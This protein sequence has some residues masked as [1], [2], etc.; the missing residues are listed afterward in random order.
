MRYFDNYS[1]DNV[2]SKLLYIYFA[3]AH[4]SV[5][6]FLVLEDLERFNSKVLR[7]MGSVIP[8]GIW[9]LILLIAALGFI[10]MAIQEGKSKNISMV[11]AGIVGAF[12]FGLMAMASL[13]LSVN[14]TNTTN[15]IFISSVDLLI[16][17]LGG[18]TLWRRRT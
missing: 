15:Y 13:E 3:F 16:A 4:G 10:L 18:I 5:G 17:T 6:V 14:Q 9:G 8:M 12:V 11:V 2:I 1:E 7:A